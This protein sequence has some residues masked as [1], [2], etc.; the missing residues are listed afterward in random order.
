M[1]NKAQVRAWVFVF[2]VLIDAIE[3]APRQ[4]RPTSHNAGGVAR[5]VPPTSIL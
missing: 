1:I 3:A 2:A 5:I 4:A